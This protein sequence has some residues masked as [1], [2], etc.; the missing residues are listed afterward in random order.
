[1]LATTAFER[2]PLLGIG[3]STS[4]LS[5]GYPAEATDTV[6][7]LLAER[8][9]IAGES[10]RQPNKGR[11]VLTA[12]TRDEVPEEEFLDATEPGADA[13]PSSGTGARDDGD[14]PPKDRREAIKSWWLLPAAEGGCCA[15]YDDPFTEAAA[16]NGDVAGRRKPSKK[17]T[18]PAVDA[19]ADVAATAGV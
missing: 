4:L 3:L 19:P 1:L 2:E 17:R 16:S 11:R 10:G 6:S 9:A 12:A 7:G 13:I 5:A 14:G 8:P 15:A 18:G